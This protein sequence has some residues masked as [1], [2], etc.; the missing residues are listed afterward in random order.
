MKATTSLVTAGPYRVSRNPIYVGY[1]FLQLGV[2]LLADSAWVLA[3]LPF[4]LLLLR[5]LVVLR[6]ERYLEAKF[7]QAYREYR[8]RVRAGSDADRGQAA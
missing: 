1:A 3:T 2:A 8:A 4:V 6:E 5:Q 7:G